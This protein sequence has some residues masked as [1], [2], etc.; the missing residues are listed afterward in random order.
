MVTSVLQR[1]LS[2]FHY[3]VL[4]EPVHEMPYAQVGLNQFVAADIA[5]ILKGNKV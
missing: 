4:V 3:H 2:I 1:F 5:N